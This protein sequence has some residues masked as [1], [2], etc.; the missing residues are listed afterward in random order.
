MNY[1]HQIFASVLVFFCN[2]A[3]LFNF[4]YFSCILCVK[5]S[6]NA[7]IQ[8]TDLPTQNNQYVNPYNWTDSQRDPIKSQITK[9]NNRIPLTVTYS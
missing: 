9:Q 4:Q 8:D 7:G 2:I 6:I 5:I 3:R 1:G